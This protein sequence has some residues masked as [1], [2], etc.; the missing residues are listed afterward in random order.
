[1]L[2]LHTKTRIHRNIH[3]NWE[4]GDSWKK[5]TAT[6]AHSAKCECLL[7]LLLSTAETTFSLTHFVL[8]GYETL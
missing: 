8:I 6:L 1:M 4:Y 5:N 2:H 7:V 3:G